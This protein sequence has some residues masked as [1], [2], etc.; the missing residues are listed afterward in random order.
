MILCKMTIDLGV[1][2]SKSVDLN[3]LIDLSSEFEQVEE[4]F[5]LSLSSADGF[6]TLLFIVGKLF[7]LCTSFP[8]DPG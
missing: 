5:I 7:L 6:S 3:S 4:G 8:I 2:R 1:S